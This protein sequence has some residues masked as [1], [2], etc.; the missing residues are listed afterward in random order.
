MHL[1]TS[2]YQDNAGCYH[3]W[4][5]VS[6]VGIRLRKK[7]RICVAEEELRGLWLSCFTT[8]CRVCCYAWYCENGEAIHTLLSVLLLPLDLFMAYVFVFSVTVGL[9]CILII[10]NKGKAL[11]WLLKMLL[12]FSFHLEDMSI[13]S[14]LKC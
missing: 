13:W 1:V 2:L 5:E 11:I 10:S 4:L 7:K 8:Q 14:R 12:N 9:S 3:T 6:P